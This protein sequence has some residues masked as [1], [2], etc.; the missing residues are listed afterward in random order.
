MESIHIITKN[1]S[2]NTARSLSKLFGKFIS[3]K[4]VL[5]NAAQSKARNLH[6]IIQADLTWDK[7]IRL[8]MNRLGHSGNYFWGK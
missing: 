7:R 6:K 4:F 8:H 3:T 5:G 1:L 2:Y